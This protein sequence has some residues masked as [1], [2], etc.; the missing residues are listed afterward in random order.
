M[1]FVRGPWCPNNVWLGGW[2][3]KAPRKDVEANGAEAP[4]EK[5][6]TDEEK[7]AS[8]EASVDVV[9]ASER[10]TGANARPS[11]ADRDAEPEQHHEKP[12]ET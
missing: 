12:I 3:H 2:G 9:P 5:K 10:G 1:L 4:E 7:G 11:D 8:T 6:G